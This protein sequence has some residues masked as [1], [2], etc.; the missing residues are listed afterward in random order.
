MTKSDSLDQLLKFSRAVCLV[1]ILQ[2]AHCLL[3]N[4]TDIIQVVDFD[5]LLLDQARHEIIIMVELK[6]LDVEILRWN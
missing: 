6:E 1:L 4:H 5:F 2:G 3:Q